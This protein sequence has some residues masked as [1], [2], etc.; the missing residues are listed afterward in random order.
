MVIEQTVAERTFLA[1]FKI[2]KMV[3]CGEGYIPVDLF[4]EISFIQAG[5]IVGLSVGLDNILIVVALMQDL[6]HGLGGIDRRGFVPVVAVP[7]FFI[8]R[9]LHP[10]HKSV[11]LGTPLT[12]HEKRALAVTFILCLYNQRDYQHVDSH[13]QK[14]VGYLDKGAGGNG[15]IDVNLF[16]YQWQQGT[17]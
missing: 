5:P 13:A 8:P 17:P 14:V 15:G 7:L 1:G 12:Y 11:L 9:S 3:I 2:H 4:G 10:D 6:A 16:K